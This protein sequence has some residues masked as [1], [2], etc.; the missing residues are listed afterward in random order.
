MLLW[1][2]DCSAVPA[3]SR[4][5]T[6][7]MAMKACEYR[8]PGY[9][10]YVQYYWLWPVVHIK[11]VQRPLFPISWLQLIRFPSE[12]QRVARDRCDV[13]RGYNGHPIIINKRSQ[14]SLTYCYVS[15]DAERP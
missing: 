15:L 11:C 6:E 3:Y 4:A 12:K 14:T 2:G 8:S 9:C 10:F 7:G 13:G 1:S 5:L